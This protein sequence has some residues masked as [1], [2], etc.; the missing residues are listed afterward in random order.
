MD[1]TYI[2]Q[3][4]LPDPLT[5]SERYIHDLAK[6][7]SK[8]YSVEIIATGRSE[9]NGKKLIY[10]DICVRTFTESSIGYKASK[11]TNK[12]RRLNKQWLLDVYAKPFNGFFHSTSWGY[13][14]SS[15]KN[16]LET[17]EFELIHSAAIPTATAWLSW[18]VSQRKNIPFVIIPFLHYELIDFR[19]PWVK[20]LLRDSTNIIAVT[21]KEKD[22]LIE[23]GVRASNIHVIPLG[24][25]YRIYAKRD[26]SLFRRSSGLT[27]DLFVILIPR[28]SKEKGT[29]STLKAM[30]NLS[31]K[32]KKLGLILLDKTSKRDEPILM[33]YLRTL[34][35]NGVKV[36]D[37][38]YV[39]GQTLIEAYQASDVV[40][41][42]T[43][44]DSFGMVFLEAWACGKP[45]I[46][47]NYGAIPEIIN[48]GSN[49]F[50]VKFGDWEEIERAIITFIHDVNLKIKLGEKG[51]QDVIKKYSIENM[52]QKTER[53]YDSIKNK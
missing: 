27:E 2:S 51:R 3:R 53:I 21:E 10:D 23:F 46:A 48:N 45:V 38:G 49:G 9:N 35:L 41:Q 30:V 52:I 13:F 42:P 44:V 36:I 39:S 43:S 34:T 25:D 18:R 28:K 40:V 17:H 1:I 11:I 19:V 33:E 26:L 7:M 16:Y 22:V 24:I 32:Y 29:Y 12:I 31:Q 4:T 8:K 47:A 15:M 37:L 50:L 14:S 20:S 6:Y 5:G